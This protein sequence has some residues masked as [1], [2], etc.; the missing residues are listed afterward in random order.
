MRTS[1]S[2]TSRKRSASQA[3]RAVS[4][5]GGAAIRAISICHCVSCGSWVR[6]QLNADRTSGEAARRATSCCTVGATSGKSARGGCG[7]MRVMGSSY[8]VAEETGIAE[9]E[10]WSRAI[11]AALERIFS[12]RPL[13]QGGLGAKGGAWYA[14]PM[15]EPAFSGVGQAQSARVAHPSQ[16]FHLHR[17][18]QQRG[19]E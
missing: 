7:L 2:P 5:N 16:P 11:R 9:I 19:S 4:P 8:N 12:Q 17:A 14:E 15:L 13:L 10:D 3:P 1:S 6:S 18:S